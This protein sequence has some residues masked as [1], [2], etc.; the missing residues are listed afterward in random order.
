MYD[1]MFGMSLRFEV[2]VDGFD[3]GTWSKCDGLTVEFGVLSHADGTED[4]VSLSPGRTTYQSITLTRPVTPASKAVTG[5]LSA[6][7]RRPFKGTGAIVLMDSANLPVMTWELAGVLP[8]KYSGPTLDV[9]AASVATES[10]VLAH[11][12]FLY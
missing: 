3:L 7:R 1:L 6:Q 8:L 11:E 5:W 9:S 2:T 10:L 12:G 4:H